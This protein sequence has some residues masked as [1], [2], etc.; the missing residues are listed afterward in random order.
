MS[1]SSVIKVISMAE[2]QWALAA[3]TPLKD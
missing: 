2:D 1:R 3:T